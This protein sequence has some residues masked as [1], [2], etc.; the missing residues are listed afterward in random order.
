MNALRGIR[1]WLGNLFN[2]RA[3]RRQIHED[4][5]LFQR[6]YDMAF[7]S[8]RCGFPIDVVR[9]SSAACTQYFAQGAM[10]AC[11]DWDEGKR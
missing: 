1:R 6:G 2:T 9:S 10:F 11:K 3:I 5:L 7:D 4:K 8:L